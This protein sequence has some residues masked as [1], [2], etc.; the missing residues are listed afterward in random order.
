MEE[1]T[2][3][4]ITGRLVPAEHITL[5][6]SGIKRDGES[7]VRHWCVRAP[8]ELQS[9]D[10]DITNAQWK[11]LCSVVKPPFANVCDNGPGRLF[12]FCP[13]ATQYVEHD[14]PAGSMM[15]MIRQSGG[16]DC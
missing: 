15:V 8:G 16:R 6:A 11:E 1:E 10:G 13:C 14:N 9:E 4:T 2:M 12:V 7:W 5:L 3:T